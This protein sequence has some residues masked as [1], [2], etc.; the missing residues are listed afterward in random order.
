MD[1]LDYTKERKVIWGPN[2]FFDG[3]MIVEI[4]DHEDL[5]VGLLMRAR[6][7]AGHPLLKMGKDYP[8]APPLHLHFDQTESFKVLQGA[9]GFTT[10]YDLKDHVITADSPPIHVRPMMPHRPCPVAGQTGR[11]EDTVVL[12]WVHPTSTDQPLGSTFFTELFQ[13]T[14][15]A[16]EQ[17]KT[18][19]IMLLLHAQHQTASANVMF[20]SLTFL[21]P[22]RWWIPW[23]L[24]AGVA[25]IVDLLGY[26]PLGTAEVK[27]EL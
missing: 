27:K 3:S 19:P 7:P 9:Y 11:G 4:L 10:G 18:P 1:E 26:K 20:P 2:K 17:K 12:L 21:G 8:Q 13:V 15:D 22:L 14:S 5:D 16:Y 25:A 24:Q 23:K 6:F